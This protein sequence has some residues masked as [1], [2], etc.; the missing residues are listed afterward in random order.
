MITK[1]RLQWGLLRSI[2]IYFA[3]PFRMGR[4]ARFY[5]QFVEPG[6]LCFDV[7]AHV[8][9]HIAAWLRLDARVIAVEPQPQLMVW[10]QQTYGPRP[11]VTLIEAAAGSEPGKQ[12]LYL[13]QRTPTVSTLSQQWMAA[14][15][16][17]ASFAGVKWDAVLSVPVITLDTL[18]ERYGKPAFCK[19]DVEGYELEVLR[20]LSMPV[21]ALSFE[22]I[23]ASLDTAVACIERLAHLGQYEYNWSTDESHRLQ[24]ATWLNPTDMVTQLQS[25]AG[26]SRSGDIYGRLVKE[27]IGD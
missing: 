7:G 13:S 2:L 3:I 15:K 27:E 9:N 20:G 22:Y 17:D 6:D 24:S 12:T 4:L 10:L 1:L 25:I 23:P 8:G 26:N 18:I 21:R 11:D 16:R 19:I 14:V 5:A